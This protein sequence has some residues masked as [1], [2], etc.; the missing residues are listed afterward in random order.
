MTT[1]PKIGL[2]IQGGHL[3][4]N[5][6]TQQGHY[7]KL[8]L[9][10]CGYE[11]DLISTNPIDSYK[12]LGHDVRVIGS[13]FD[14]SEYKLVI[15]VSALL[16][17]NDAENTLFLQNAKNAGVKFVNL[18]CGNIFF[19]Y[20]EE[21]IFNV[22]HILES[23]INTFIDEVWV[24]PMYTHSVQ[25]LE[26]FFKKPVRVAP[27]IWNSDI[28]KHTWKGKEMPFYVP[29]TPADEVTA[30]SVEPN[31]SVHKNAFSPFLICEDYFNKFKKLKSM[32][33]L[34]GKKLH[35][36]DLYQYLDFMKAGK[37]EL[38]DRLSFT[39]ILNQAKERKMQLPV[40]V[41]H[42]YL[43]ELNFVHFETLFL[44]WPLVHNCKRLIRVGYY[45]DCDDV[46]TG[47][48]QM[49][50]A[51]LMHSRNIAQYKEKVDAFL[52]QYSPTN[53]YVTEVYTNL[54]DNIVSCDT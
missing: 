13:N 45:Y 16:C 41:S 51:R 10:A 1:K 36:K 12:E 23:H 8:A 2:F 49:E 50:Y 42:Q 52:E 44:G 34:C 18:I 17:S 28:L 9:E 11:A 27:Y 24:L 40:V 39:D 48:T 29:D 15:F 37:L 46:A 5:G 35:L 26:V 31:M 47:S 32:C 25:M 33:V 4:S 38:Y 19:L 20:Q 14:M 3:L 22:H 43:N 54:V 53:D 30:F 6:I 7:T 21:I